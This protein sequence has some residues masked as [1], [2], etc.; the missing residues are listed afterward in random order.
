MIKLQRWGLSKNSLLQKNRKTEA[1]EY[2]LQE[3][4]HLI[5][6]GYTSGILDD[7]ETGTRLSWEL[8][9]DIF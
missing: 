2:D 8:K 4:S 1:N 6:E 3:I 7:E 9:I 5:Q